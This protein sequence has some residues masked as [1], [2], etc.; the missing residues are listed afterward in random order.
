MGKDSK[1]VLVLEGMP[2]RCAECPLC[3]YGDDLDLHC[4][5]NSCYLGVLNG[6]KKRPESCPLLPLDKF[7]E[8]ERRE[9]HGD[10]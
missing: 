6:P 3:R 5:P 1:V 7:L 9:Q 4:V 10:E 8:Q 2:K